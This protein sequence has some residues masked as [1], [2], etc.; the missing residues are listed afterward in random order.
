M[1]YILIYR[2]SDV[3][4]NHKQKME[5]RSKW[6]EWNSYL[7]ETYGIRTARGKIVTAEGVEEYTG[8]FKGASIIEVGSL[9]EAVEI[10]KRSPTIKLGGVVEVFEE[11]QH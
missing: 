2:S 6:D 10:A 3:L 7:K 5:S 4:L 1:T 8:D 9:E 11:F